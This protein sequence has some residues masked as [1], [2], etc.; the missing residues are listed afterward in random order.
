MNK[1]P[2]ELLQ[3]KKAEIIPWKGVVDLDLG[4][5]IEVCCQNV[6]L[7]TVYKNIFPDSNFSISKG[8]LD[9]F[10]NMLF[11]GK[12]DIIKKFN[13]KL[14]NLPIKKVKSNFSQFE[15][16]SQFI[17]TVYTQFIKD[18]N[19]NFQKKRGITYTPS[20]I[21]K[22]MIETIDSILIRHFKSPLGIASEDLILYDPATGSLSFEIGLISYVYDKF[23]SKNE[24]KEIKFEDWVLKSFNNSF[25]GNELNPPAYFLGKFLLLDS[26]KPE[27]LGYNNLG[28]NFSVFFKSAL[29]PDIL[30]EIKYKTQESNKELVI[31]GNPPYAV[32]SSNKDPWT[33]ELMKAYS[34]KEPNL[35]RLYDDYVKFLR[36]GQWLL[37]QQK[38]GILAFITNRKYLDGKIFYGM[39]QSMLKSFDTIYIIDLFGD[40]R[41]IKDTGKKPNTNIFNIQTG[42]CIGFFVKDIEKNEKKSNKLARV[43]YMGIKGSLEQIKSQLNIPFE[44]FP[45]IELSPH[46]PK[47]Y[48]IPVEL[49]NDLKKIWYEQ[50]IPITDCFQKTSRAMISSRDRFMIHVDKKSLKENIN[51]LKNSDFKQLRS[52]GRIKQKFDEILENEEI[53]SSFNFSEME[54]SIIPLNYRPFDIR[55]GIFYTINRKCGKSIILDYLNKPNMNFNPKEEKYENK[56]N[57]TNSGYAFNFV[58]S[59]Q[60][61]PFSHILFTKGVVDSGLFGYSTSKVAPLWIDGK[62]NISPKFTAMLQN[63]VSQTDPTQ[64][65]GYIYA[66][67]N[68]ELFTKKFEPILIHEFP[69]VLVPYSSRFFEMMSVLGIKLMNIHVFEFD[70]EQ[71]EKYQNFYEQ[72]SFIPDSFQL[73]NWKYEPEKDEL[74]LI[75]EKKKELFKLHCPKEVW[76]YKIGSIKIIDHWLK[77]RIFKKLERS[78]DKDE[79]TRII[80]LLFI[81]KETIHMKIQINEG[82]S[83]GFSP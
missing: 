16:I 9:Q 39:R 25:L 8:F 2:K 78:L 17:Q 23:K 68:C 76:N 62:S 57:D 51:S 30:K 1:I 6:C 38:R 47:F 73:K 5:F 83:I 40:I 41:N 55:H 34:V 54:S 26:L 19:P 82:F 65:S 29:S 61:P 72:I 27:E 59:I 66:I 58:Q 7:L 49:E 22:T 56:F 28:E 42:V 52:K 80:L 64:I 71:W 75:S 46:S 24:E 50:C 4:V 13:K 60:H 31:F 69:R 45:F 53:L 81:I 12:E 20:F 77:A 67:L 36:L 15:S 14:N 21:I 74:K 43:F 32:S 44:K 10:W 48:F 18:Y 35:T 63:I 70:S 37:E 33:Y 79:L 11:A 3:T